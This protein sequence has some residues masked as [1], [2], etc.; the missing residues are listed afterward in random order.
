LG[1]F[2]HF[3]QP[4]GI[5]MIRPATVL[6]VALLAAGCSTVTKPTVN[7]LP[8]VQPQVSPTL[9]QADF[10]GLKRKVAIARFSN[11]TSAGASFL[12]DGMND[13][14]GKQ[15]SDILAAR[16]AETRKFILLERADLDKIQNEAALANLDKV[17]V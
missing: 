16:L 2:H 5:Y 17:N 14:I 3:I 4:K 12:L 15:A 7:S 13:R 10:K 1:N 6:T 9:Q 8:V 11:E